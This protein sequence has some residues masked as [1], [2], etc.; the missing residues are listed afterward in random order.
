MKKIMVIMRM[1]NV[2]VVYLIGLLVVGIGYLDV[3]FVQKEEIYGQLQRAKK[4]TC[5]KIRLESFLYSHTLRI[6]YSH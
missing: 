6:A 5:A 2:V 1:N 3:V 4:I